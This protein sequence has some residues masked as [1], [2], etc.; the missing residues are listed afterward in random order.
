MS[1]AYS[2][3]VLAAGGR[4][5]AAYAEIERSATQHAIPGLSMVFIIFLWMERGAVS[6]GAGM[7]VSGG[8]DAETLRR[9][10][11]AECGA[12]SPKPRGG[13]FGCVMPKPA[14]EGSGYNSPYAAA[15]EEALCATRI[16]LNKTGWSM[17]LAGW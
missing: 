5:S 9:G 10:G 1:R 8:F 6:E 3:L 17:K 12:H 11:N 15:N 2:I 16:I 7:S 13:L 4:S 14:P